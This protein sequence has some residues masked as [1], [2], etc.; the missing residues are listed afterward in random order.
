MNEKK[1][2][3]RQIFDVVEESLADSLTTPAESPSHET[4]LSSP[5][6]T[7]GDGVD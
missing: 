1:N 4:V 2:A 7:E 6:S 3:F 5:Q